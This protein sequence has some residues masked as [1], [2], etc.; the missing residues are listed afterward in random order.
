MA[1]VKQLLYRLGVW[2]YTGLCLVVLVTLALH[3][4]IIMVPDTPAF[5]EEYYVKDARYILQGQGTDRIEHPP[6][7]KLFIALGMLLF[8]DNPFGWRFFSVIFGSAGIVL[9]YLICRRLSMS[10]DSS[11]FA[12]CLLAVE[13]LSFIQASVAMLDVYSVTLML[14]SFWLYLRGQYLASGVSIGLSTLAKLSGALGLI[15]IGLHWLIAGRKRPW[16]FLVSMA[17]AP[18]SF[19]VLMPLLDLAMWHRLTNPI[20]EIKTMLA[21]SISSTLSPDAVQKFSRPWEWILKPESLVYWANPHYIGMIS[22]SIWALIIPVVGYLIYRT[23]KGSQPAHFGL[24]WFVSTYLVWIPISLILNRQSYIYYFYPAIGAICI[25][26]AQGLSELSAAGTVRLKKALK[27]LVPG[28]LV[29]HL[30]TFVFVSPVSPYVA[31]PLCSVLY[32]VMRW[33]RT[34]AGLSGS[35][36]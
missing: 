19:L 34:G 21:I 9:F 5:D 27:M 10:R 16:R 15:A 30:A 33:Q 28:Y 17:L 2:E 32:L 8:G 29:I 1:R 14:A 12:A 25:G 22:P 3:F 23:V 6:L 4:S 35:G 18:A 36:D 20:S 26:L 7:G 24:W 31:V 11:L 13:N